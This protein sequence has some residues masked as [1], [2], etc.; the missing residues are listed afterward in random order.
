MLAIHSQLT[1]R[2][3]QCDAVDL[4]ALAANALDSLL[5]AT[6]SARRKARKSGRRGM[7][8]N[9]VVNP[10][11]VSSRAS[12]A[13]GNT[14]PFVREWIDRP[15][16]PMPGSEPI[17]HTAPSL[18]TISLF[19]G[20]PLLL[21]NSYDSQFWAR[22]F[23][24]EFDAPPDVLDMFFPSEDPEV[25]DAAMGGGSNDGGLFMGMD[26]T[27]DATGN[28]GT[29]SLGGSAIWSAVSGPIGSSS[30]GDGWARVSPYGNSGSGLGGT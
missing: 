30:G 19:P 6:T 10:V 21:E 28:T 24:L 12:V 1:I 18:S 16:T 17:S 8:I 27:P 14:P 9:D 23:D 22:I 3:E 4:F 11:N 20:T 7:D 29:G 26:T 15:N 25:D 2:R 13:S 5:D